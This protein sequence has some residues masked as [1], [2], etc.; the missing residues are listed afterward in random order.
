MIDASE[1]YATALERFV[2]ER[3]VL[4]KALRG[5]GRRAEAEHVAKLPKPSVAAWAVNQLVRTQV[6]AT[7]DLFEA[8]D[9]LAGAQAEVLAGQG[10]AAALRDAA[11]H[12]RAAV[13]VLVGMARGLP[14]GD[15]VG[16]NPAMLERV[17]ET[18][19]AAALDARAREA[20]RHGCLVREL[21]HIGLGEGSL[22]GAAASPP[23]KPSLAKPSA[24]AA[25]PSA[26]AAKRDVSKAAPSAAAERAA[27]SAAESAAEAERDAELAAEA[28]RERL[29]RLEA[30]RQHARDAA[31]A[32]ERAGRELD[33]AQ[34]RYDYAAATF[35]EA[36]KALKT[37][38]ENSERTKQAHR[39]AEK[40]VEG[41]KP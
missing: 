30:A 12:E 41:L 19:H 21:K 9:A 10:S 1:L 20:V 5:E 15:G 22:A 13:A 14:S 2:P 37:A 11:E 25:K 4:A 34:A 26:E 28:E 18:L 32:A 40:A 31:R 38:A 8:G 29:A 24:E 33:S 6:V 17:A 16:L 36:E 39:Q 35:R 23:L 7:N 3:A 27:Q